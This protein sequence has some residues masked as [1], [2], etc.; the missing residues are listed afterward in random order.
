MPLIYITYPT[1]MLSHAVRDTLAEELTN[2]ALDCE[3]LPA[4]PFVK[5]T[6]WIYFHEL[7]S[8][9]VYQGS[10]KDLG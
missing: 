6:T 4:S 9:H 2:I 10:G 5:S 3:K 8:G 1:G 7:P